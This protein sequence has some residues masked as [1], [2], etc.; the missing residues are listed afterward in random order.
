MNKKNNKMGTMSMGKL[1]TNISVPLMISMLVQSLYNIVDGIFV[2]KISE[3]ALT[4]TSIAYP[5]QMLMLAVA[6]GTGV[7]VNALLSRRLGQKDHD[8]ANKVATTGLALSLICSLIFVVAG[9]AGSRAFINAFAKNEE[10]ALYGTQYLRICMIGCAGIFLATTGERLLQS[11][12]N[13]F[14]SMIAQS[15][16]ALVNI[17]LDPILIFGLIGFPELGIRGAAIA[18][19]IG[20]FA[21]AAVS[22]GLNAAKNKEIRFL[23]RDFSM[24]G[25]IVLEIYKV[26]IPTML[27]QTMGS[28]M[29]VCMNAYLVIFSSTAV[30]AFG[31]YYK[32]W[33][34]VYMPVSGLSQGLIP[35][36]G[37]NYG[38]KN[39][40]RVMQA[41][42]I[43]AAASVVTMLVGTLLFELFPRQLLSLYDAGE[44]LMEIGVPLLRIMAVTFPLAAVTITIGFACS[45]L[46]NGMVSMIGTLLRQLVLLVP[47]ARLFGGWWGIDCVWYAAW[48]SETAAAVFAVICF[49]GQYKKKIRPIRHFQ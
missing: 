26:G 35:I 29:M 4:A 8:G 27:M 14:L 13:T 39:G 11:T 32:L 22:L 7:G 12:G 23:I 25:S 34:F 9:I 20:Q 38:A 43:T 5:A 36:I 1:V 37:F 15:A 10:I 44:Q 49:I 3:N 40:E 30:A 17:M 45:G 48:I 42:K 24:D 2:A 16:G 19:V 21:A 46:G 28:I 6:V 18:T 31:V 47:F 41:Y 33:T